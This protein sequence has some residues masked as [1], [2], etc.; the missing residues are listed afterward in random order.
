MYKNCEYNMCVCVCVSHRHRQQCGD[1]GKSGGVVGKGG[2][3][4]DRKRYCLGQWAHDAV[5]R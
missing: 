5:Y 3:N 4:G 1:R 2:I